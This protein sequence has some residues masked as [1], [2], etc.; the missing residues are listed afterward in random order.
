MGW[1]WE[2]REENEKTRDEW[3]DKRKKSSFGKSAGLERW[4]GLG[5]RQK[6]FKEKHQGKWGIKGY[7]GGQ[8]NNQYREG[9]DD[10]RGKTGGEDEW[11]LSVRKKDAQCLP[12]TAMGPQWWKFLIGCQVNTNGFLVFT[13]YMCMFLASIKL[14]FLSQ[15]SFGRMV[16]GVK[17][18]KKASILCE[19]NLCSS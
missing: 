4:W 13:V 7:L 6:R 15:I 11:L 9:V 2:G 18:L 1:L 19:I 16:P 5:Q 12:C 3:K 10:D 8:R 17:L 14:W